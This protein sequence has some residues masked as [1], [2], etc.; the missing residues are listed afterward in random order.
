VLVVATDSVVDVKSFTVTVLDPVDGTPRLIPPPAVDYLGCLK[1]PSN[2]GDRLNATFET[3]PGLANKDH[4]SFR[5]VNV[6]NHYLVPADDRIQL[7]KF[8]DWEGYRRNGSFKQVK[9]LASANGVSFE[10]VNSPGH[11]I[12]ARNGK[13]FLEKSDESDHFRREATFVITK[14]QFKLW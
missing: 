6:P 4:V 5:S 14:P 8:E 3:V 2:D 9:G 11:H 12:C 10:S 7:Q 13:R 1:E